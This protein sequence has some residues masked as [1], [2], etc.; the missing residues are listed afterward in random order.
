ML[1][2]TPFILN[3]AQRGD[4]FALLQSLPDGCTSMMYAAHRLG[5]EFIG[6][7]LIVPTDNGRGA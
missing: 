7:D 3:V 4:A 1:D 5:R 6:C 2:R